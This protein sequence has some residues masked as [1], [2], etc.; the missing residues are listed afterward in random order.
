MQALL[1]LY[2]HQLVVFLLVLT[3]VSGVVL[4]APLLSAQ[5]AP[6][7]V[8]AMLAIALAALVTPLA[9]GEVYFEHPPENLIDLMILAGGELVVG[10]SL[11]LGITILFAGLQLTGQI[12]GQM[13]GMQLADIFDPGFDTS[14]PLFSRLLDL[15]TMAVFL[16]IG[17]HRQVIQALL[18]TF[19]WMPPG[20]A[21][22]SEGIVSMLMDL[23]TQ[24]F[25]LGLRAAA[26]V[27]VALLLAVL[28]LGLVSRTLPQLNVMA[29]GFSFNSMVMLATLA[30]SLGAIA[31]VF[32][33]QAA[34]A[35][36]TIRASLGAPF[37]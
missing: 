19:V 9:A 21:R 30:I 25:V 20:E 1:T 12:A 3:R 35:L 4:T 26:P 29:V 27:M 8:R 15:V 5:T 23:T 2:Q 11:G 24:S 31:W 16:A 17:G 33:E 14:V 13:S 10:L 18:D 28:V 32:Q 7:R 34:L 22:F 36:E 37:S 6:I